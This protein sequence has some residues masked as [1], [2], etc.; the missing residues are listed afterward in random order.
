MGKESIKIVVKGVF[1]VGLL[2]KN[3]SSHS[4]S[5]ETRELYNQKLMEK[6]KEKIEIACKWL[7]C[8]HAIN[9]SINQIHN[10]ELGQKNQGK[11]LWE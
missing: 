11:C 8:P 10:Y 7:Y 3:E 4:T 5:A 1:Y 9:Q 2:P 6:W